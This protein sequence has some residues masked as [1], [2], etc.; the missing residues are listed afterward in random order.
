MEFKKTLQDIFDKSLELSKKGFE[1]AKEAGAIGIKQLEIK[2][3]EHKI[4]K[5]IGE[6]GAI[7]FDHFIKVKTPLEKDSKGIP[8]ILKTINDLEQSIKQKEKELKDIK[9]NK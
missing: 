4:A 8:D 5:K 7:A 1:K 9:K 2:T 3:V 6:L